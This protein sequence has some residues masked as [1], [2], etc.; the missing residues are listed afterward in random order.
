M[1][2][3]GGIISYLGTWEDHFLHSF[4]TLTKA[5]GFVPLGTEYS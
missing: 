2:F 4:V 3:E 1:R 5:I